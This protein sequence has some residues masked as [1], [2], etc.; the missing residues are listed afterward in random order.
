MRRKKAL[1]QNSRIDGPRSGHH[2]QE[3]AQARKQQEGEGNRREQALEGEGAR[4][5]RDVVFVGGLQGPP[6]EAVNRSIPGPTPSFGQATGSSSSAASA[7]WRR[8]L[9]SV[10]RRSSS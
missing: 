6:D 9:A 3:L 5:K 4:Q 2:L 7:R 10:S 1:E 8:A